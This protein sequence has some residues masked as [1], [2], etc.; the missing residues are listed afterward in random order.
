ML[1]DLVRLRD[2]VYEQVDRTHK[3]R[4][5]AELYLLAGLVCGLLSSVSFDLRRL[6]LGPPRWWLGW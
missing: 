5:Q 6:R 1:T 2:T 4:Q 3:P